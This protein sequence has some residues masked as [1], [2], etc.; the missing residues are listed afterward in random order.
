ME[1]F[2]TKNTAPTLDKHRIRTGSC[3]YTIGMHICLY[4]DYCTN[5][6]PTDGLQY[7]IIYFP[8]CPATRIKHWRLHEED[9]AA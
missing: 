2:E 3:R 9:P 4:A 6:K 5:L 1:R 7:G 8:L